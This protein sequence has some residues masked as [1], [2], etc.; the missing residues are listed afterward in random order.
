MRGLD[1]LRVSGMP[2][3]ITRIAMEHNSKDVHFVNAKHA[4][5]KIPIMKESEK[6]NGL[7]NL[8]SPGN[9]SSQQNCRPA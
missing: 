4:L 8:I 3:G 5:M 7:T 9:G 2:E 1:G 6:T